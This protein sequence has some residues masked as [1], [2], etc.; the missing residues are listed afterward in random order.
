MRTA[1][2]SAVWEHRSH[3]PWVRRS[4]SNRL[5]IIAVP[6]SCA[7]SEMTPIH[8]LA[9]DNLKGMGRDLRELPKTVIYNPKLSCELPPGL[10]FVSGHNAIAHAAEVLYAHDS[11]PVMSLMAEDGIRALATDCAASRTS[12]KAC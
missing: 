8:G 3:E 5:P 7:G 10:S 11:N 6:T 12:P 4:R 2:A 1:R 9:G